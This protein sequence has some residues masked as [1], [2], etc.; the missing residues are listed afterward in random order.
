MAKF[1][2]IEEQLLKDIANNR[3]RSNLAQIR[4]AME[5]I[6]ASD[7]PRIIRDCTYHD[8]THCERVVENFKNKLLEVNQ[9]KPISAQEM[10]LVLAGI[11]L[12][13][14][15]MQCDVIRFPEIKERAEKMGAEF[16][17][18][19]TAST[20]SSYSIDEQKAI[21]K[22]H[23]YFSAAWIEYA[24]ETGDSV[25]GPAAKTIPSNLVEDLMDVCKYHSKLPID[26]CDEKFKFNSNERKRLIGAMLRFSDELDIASNRVSFETVR[27]FRLDPHDEIYWWLHNQTEIS[28]YTPYAIEVVIQMR[29]EDKEKYGPLVKS[30]FIDGF[31]NKNAQILETLVNNKIQINISTTSDVKENRFLREPFP[32]EI[33]QVL[34]EMQERKEREE[35]KRK[36]IPISEEEYKVPAKDLFGREEEIEKCL[37][38]LKGYSFAIVGIKGIGKSKLLSA[39]FEKIIK[40]K[41][42]QF[43]RYYWRRLNYDKPPSFSEF[44]RRLI[45][46]LTDEDID[47]GGSTV[48]EQV[49]LVINTIEKNSCLVIIDQ[50]EVLVDRKTLKPKDEGF[51]KFLTC[52]RNLES[53]RLILTA[54]VIPKDSEE[55]EFHHIFLKGVDESAGIEILKRGIS[56]EDRPILEKSVED[57]RTLVR[58]KMQG[59]PGALEWIAPS[60]SSTGIQT[61]INDDILWLGKLEKITTNVVSRAYKR[62]S[63]DS[64]LKKAL[65]SVCIFLKPCDLKAFSFVTDMPERESLHALNELIQR[66]LVSRPQE[67][68]YDVHAIVR[69]YVLSQLKDK[70]KIYLH[71]K[72][73]DFYLNQ[74]SLLSEH[75]KSIEDIYPLLDAIEHLISAERTKETVELF[76]KEGLHDK[77]FS[78]CYFRELM[79]IYKGFEEKRKE[80]PED[81]L[82]ILLGNL[83]L[84]FRD[85]GDIQEA[86]RYYKEALSIAQVCQD[87]NSE[88][89]QLVNLGDVC[90]FLGEIDESIEYHN[91]AKAFFKEIKNRKIEGRNFG[92]LGNALHSKGDLEKAEEYYKQAIDICREP[93]SKDR[94]YE[95]IWLGDLGNIYEERDEHKKAIECYEL[96]H[97]IAIETKDRRHESWWLGVLG[98]QYYKSGYSSKA[99]DFLKDALSISKSILF[100]KGIHYQLSSLG[101]IYW[102]SAEFLEAIEYYKEAVKISK[103]MRSLE[104]EISDLWNI[105]IVYFDLLEF[106]Q[107]IEYFE[108]GLDIAKKMR[109]RQHES[110]IL[111]KIGESY[112]KL[113]QFDKAIGYLSK[114][115]KIAQEDEDLQNEGNYISMLGDVYIKSGQSDKAME[116]FI[117]AENIAKEIGDE[118]YED[119]VQDFFKEKI[120][121]WD[122][123][124]KKIG[125]LSDELSNAKENKDLTNQMKALCNLGNIY[126][127]LSQFK[128]AE[129]YYRDGLEIAKKIGDK[130]QEGSFV[131]NLGNLSFFSNQFSKAIDYYHQ[132]IAVAKGSGDFISEGVYSNQLCKIYLAEANQL[133]KNDQIETALEE[134]DKAI[135]IGSNLAKTYEMVGDI[136]LKLGKSKDNNKFFDNGIENYTRAIQIKPTSSLFHG[137]GNCYVYKKDLEKAISDYGE[138]IRLNPQNIAAIMSKMEIEIWLCRYSEARKTYKDIR[139]NRLSHQYRVIAAHF[140]CLALSLEGIPYE[141]YMASLK[142]I[143]IKLFK[144]IYDPNDIEPYISEPKLKELGISQDR[145]DNALIIHNLFK[146]HYLSEED[147]IKYKQALKE[148]NDLFKK[149]NLEK[150]AEKYTEVLEINPSFA[151]AYNRR[152]ICYRILAVCSP[153]YAENYLNMAIQDFT[154]AIKIE[155]GNDNNYMQRAG[156]YSQKGD[157]VNS[158]PDYQMATG[159]NPLNKMAFLGEMEVKICLR[160]YNEVIATY[161]RLT[162]GTLLDKEKVIAASLVCIALALEGKD[163]KNYIDPL[164]DMEVKLTDISGKHEW[165]TVEIDWHLTELEKENYMPDRVAIAKEIQALFKNH[166]V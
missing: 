94:R 15:G 24:Y 145:I 54:W 2:A 52:S 96:A 92:C 57:I 100:R 132:A 146:K 141:D 108:Y 90:H 118:Q 72:A 134:C 161:K 69:E 32:P 93:E 149:D 166:F 103:E 20:S 109:N 124:N 71:S 157:L 48:D 13:D 127:L 49:Q 131:S 70:E 51:A 155:P 22:N 16:D 137:R 158:I 138:A 130:Q 34:E 17:V 10:Y 47:F 129:E 1:S 56:E 126:A 110:N 107:A 125:S 119:S 101:N 120:K 117:Q 4:E 148:A 163:Y 73:G 28:S 12:H 61:I 50:F 147:V 111:S 86:K 38:L 75:K 85:L 68:T 153:E 55:K 154:K 87:K 79:N 115:L 19:F 160:R 3:L 78:W 53:A 26:D 44:G 76:M 59:H 33:I 122:K 88:C 74:A 30:I 60:L 25:L 81:K 128:Q 114:A 142:D 123:K 98:N 150:A 39:L 6:W 82:S 43:K 102:A 136:Y 27:N 18:T 143:T 42:L 165:L 14:I 9:G 121:Q 105:G 23:H 84:V 144:D 162:R 65:H 97:A 41:W 83:G 152:G 139:I 40:D 29:P 66:C 8:E 62:I 112:S 64:N 135:E 46:Y 116:C 11:Y 159:L 113:E 133:F 77:L 89:T 91:L 106:Y 21:R 151:G 156:C 7:A 164:N 45:K 67:E 31:S 36:I 104:N 80:I 99:I 95:G 5:D 37:N 35:R 58:E 63:H 140:I